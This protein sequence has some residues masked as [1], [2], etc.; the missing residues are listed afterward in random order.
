MGM[1]SSSAYCAHAELRDGSRVC[2]RAIRPDDKEQLKIGF[3]RLSPR[4]VYRRF[5]HPVREI[6]ADALRDVTEVDFRDQVALV[7]TVDDETGERVI[8]EGRFVRVAPGANRAEIGVIVGDAYQGRG[9]GTLLLQHLVRLARAAGVRELVALVL[10]ENREMLDII[11][12]S[13]LP[14][15][16]S[17]EDGVRRVV[18]SLDAEP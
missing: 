14:W 9:A 7:L 18:M 13:A 1:R 15:Q 2:V 4:S 5:F 3:R 12:N 16:Q 17:T 6:T 11:E 10:D 8:A